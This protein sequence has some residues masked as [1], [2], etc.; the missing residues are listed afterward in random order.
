MMA[1]TYPRAGVASSTMAVFAHGNSLT[2]GVGASSVGNYW[3]ALASGLAPLL[4]KGI[5]I[6][7]RGVGGQSI[8]VDAGNGTMTNTA[9]AA[10]DANL[11]AGKINVLLVLE[12]TNELKA[13]GFNAAAAHTALKNYCLARKAAAASVGK[14]LQ[15][16]V[17]TCPP[18]GADPTGGGQTAINSRN[19]AMIAANALTRQQYR[20]YAD[21]LWDLAEVAPFKAIFAGGVFTQAPFIAA[22]VWARSDG[23][24]DDYT[25]FGNSGY[26]L[27]AESAA[28]AIARVR[29]AAAL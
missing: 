19:A 13:N 29:K 28:R 20:D 21:V 6:S 8:F 12:Y 27:L 15:I 3:P 18:S 22:G 7:N 2:A 24:A 25:H 9:A 1:M 26:A 17:G 11:V 23:V 10:I 5:T 4:G 14:A 16:I